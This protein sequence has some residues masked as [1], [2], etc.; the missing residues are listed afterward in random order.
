MIA[1]AIIALSMLL[2]ICILLVGI[3]KTLEYIEYQTEENNKTLKEAAK[4][5]MSI[6]LKR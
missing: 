4:Q 1:I 6:N 2:T 5:W 3:L